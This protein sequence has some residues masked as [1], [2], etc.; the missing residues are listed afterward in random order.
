[1]VASSNSMAL[2]PISEKEYQTKVKILTNV[3]LCEE[4]ASILKIFYS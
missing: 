1:M 3:K 4:S 2:P